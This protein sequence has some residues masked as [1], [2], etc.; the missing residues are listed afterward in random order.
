[1]GVDPNRVC[2][3]RLVV[4]QPS[5]LPWLGHLDQ[6]DWADHFILYDD[7][8]FDKH[9]WR[10]RNRIL[11][12]NG[13]SWI[14][15]PVKTKGLNKPLNSEVPI[16]NQGKWQKKMLASIRQSYSKTPYFGTHFPGL[17]EVISKT[18][19]FLIDL[20]LATLRW[21][22]E[23]LD[24]PWKVQRSSELGIPGRKT[25][26]LV[27]ICEKF[28]ATDYLTGDAARDYLEERQFEDA[29]IKV[30]WHS[31]EHPVYEQGIDDFVPYLSAVDLLFREGPRT[32]EILSRTK[33]R[34][35]G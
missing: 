15:V 30:H 10:N 29:G 28:K 24:L 19:D 21:L 27:A 4:L 31:Y 1:M 35:I 11:T 20:N 5:F 8:Q 7:T 17:E 26:R 33:L 18:Y 25:E 14:T 12:P 2:V 32:C 6:Y 23:C 3:T 9:G 22:T 13:V 34:S 16:N